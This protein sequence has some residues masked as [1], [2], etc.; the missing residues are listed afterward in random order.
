MVKWQARSRARRLGGLKLAAPVLALTGAGVLIF[1][2]AGGLDLTGVSAFV[3]ALLALP[4][5]AQWAV[6]A[7]RSSLDGAPGLTIT[8]R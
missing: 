8:S 4:W 2:M 7:L 6:G 3:P 1:D 5:A